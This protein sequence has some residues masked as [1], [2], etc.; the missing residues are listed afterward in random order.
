M[1]EQTGVAKTLA[2]LAARKPSFCR[3]LELEEASNAQR[4][5][6]RRHGE[7]ILALRPQENAGS[8]ERAERSLDELPFRF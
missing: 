3:K 5:I 1:P 2:C 6:E 8:A 7:L 4:I